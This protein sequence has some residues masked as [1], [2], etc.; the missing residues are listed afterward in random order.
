[1]KGKETA[2]RTSRL[3]NA[4]SDS[5]SSGATNNI[6]LQSLKVAVK[7]LV[8]EAD[9]NTVS[10][11]QIKVGLHAQFS[12]PDDFFSKD[13]T[14]PPIATETGAANNHEL[15]KKCVKECVT[16]RIKE[17]E[18][19]NN[20]SANAKDYEA[21][22]EKHGIKLKDG[23]DGKKRKGERRKETEIVIGGKRR[24]GGED[25]KR[26]P[27][28][29]VQPKRRLKRKIEESESSDNDVEEYIPEN[30]K[31]EQERSLSPSESHHSLE[32]VEV[33]A[34]CDETVTTSHSRPPPIG[35]AREKKKLKQ[36]TLSKTIRKTSRS[37]SRSTESRSGGS[38]A[39]DDGSDSKKKIRRRKNQKPVTHNRS[40]ERETSCVMS[41]TKTKTAAWRDEQIKVRD[42]L[43]AVVYQLT[44]SPAI[45]RNLS[46]DTTQPEK[47]L[48]ELKR[49]IIDFAIKNNIIT[50]SRLPNSKEIAAYRKVLTQNRELEGIDESNIIDTSSRR[51]GYERIPPRRSQCSDDNGESE[52]EG[53]KTEKEENNDAAESDTD[54]NDSSEEARDETDSSD[55]G[56]MVTSESETS[57]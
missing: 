42:R 20:I 5:P 22:T 25:T 23:R 26:P 53:D 17:E 4:S 54:D 32:E 1:M 57:S 31:N 15:I 13:S 2:N 9:L 33:K 38:L 12:L 48:E 44:K 43:R 18:E 39:S 51:R 41:E 40:G 37:R 3:S 24:T 11:N 29:L 36:S 47:Y 28:G 6:S 49:R 35:K 14:K 27:S 55:S 50:E 21:E 52:D 56:S 10:L 30:S 45:Y 19:A 7:K 46:Q 16:A 34:L 8:N